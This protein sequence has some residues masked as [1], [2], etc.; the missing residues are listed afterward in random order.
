[1]K[2]WPWSKI[3]AGVACLLVLVGVGPLAYVLWEG[4]HAQPL[5]VPLSLKRG[6]YT[7]PYFRTYLSGAYQI[8]LEWARFPDPQTVVDLDWK[9]VDDS[10]AVIQQGAYS[11]RLRGANNVNLGEYRLSFGR[12]QRI[13]TKVNQDVQGASANARLE[14][15]QPEV[16]LDISYGIL[17]ILGWT[18]IVGGFGVIMLLVL[19]IRRVIR[20]NASAAAS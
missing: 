7:S 16:S 9:I 3:L 1:M 12:R 11:D 19:L 15:G 17:L 10:G 4:A 18:A 5:S 14:I 20:R 13:L 2:K 6:D 8:Q